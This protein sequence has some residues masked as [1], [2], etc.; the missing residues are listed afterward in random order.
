MNE[1]LKQFLNWPSALTAGVC[2]WLSMAAAF[3]VDKKSMFVD[4]PFAF[5]VTLTLISAIFVLMHKTSRKEAWNLFKCSAWINTAGV[6]M[7]V[8]LIFKSFIPEYLHPGIAFSLVI[9]GWALFTL[10]LTKPQ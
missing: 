3:T 6:I 10:Q 9:L 8:V 2:G 5:M 7:F 1:T 4:A